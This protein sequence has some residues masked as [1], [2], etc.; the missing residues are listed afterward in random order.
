MT[1]A[2]A[3]AFCSRR[4]WL[5]DHSPNARQL[6]SRLRVERL[7]I[8]VLHPVLAAH[9]LDHELRVASELKLGRAVLG[10]ELDAADERPVLGDVVRGR[11]DWLR[12]IGDHLAALVP[13]DDADRGGARIAARAA[14]DV[15]DEPHPSAVVGGRRAG[16]RALDPKRRGDLIQDGALLLGDALASDAEKAS[17]LRRLGRMLC[18]V[19]AERLECVDLLGRCLGLEQRD[20]FGDGL[21]TAHRQLLPACQAASRSI[22]G[23]SEAISARRLPGFAWTASVYALPTAML[24]RIVPPRSAAIT[25]TAAAAGPRRP[26]PT[27]RR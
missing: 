14:V 17:G 26:D 25:I 13:D 27:P 1:R 10:G 15:Y 8:R 3:S 7:Q 23:G 21:G 5:N 20:G 18:D 11:P 12:G 4:T 19:Q 9:L 6:R 22:F 16:N 24:S 2:S